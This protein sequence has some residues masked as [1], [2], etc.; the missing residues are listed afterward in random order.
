MVFSGLFFLC[1]FLPVTLL[2]YYVSPGLKAKNIVLTLFSLLF[3]AWGEPIYFLLM[4]LC[5]YV[6]YMAAR[7]ICRGA[8]GRK[9][10]L[11]VSLTISLGFLVVFKY[12]GLMAE[13]LNLIPFV[14][15][16]VPEIAL[17]IGISFY[18]F[19]ALSY[20]LDIYSGRDEP[21]KRFIDFLLY[22]S[23]FPQLIAGPILR[24]RDL[25]S[26]LTYREHSLHRFYRG[27]V[28]F[29]VGLCKKVIIANHAGEVAGEMLA[30]SST[31]G[32]WYGIILFALQI[33]FDF[34]GYSDM[35]VGLGRM[36]GFEYIEN[37][38]YPYISRSVTEFWRR[39]HIS[40][41]T[42][43]RDY[44]YIPMGGKYRHQMLNIFTVWA[45]TGIWHGAS[46]NFLFWGLYYG[47]LLVLEKKFLLKLLSRL[48]AAV[49]WL[50][51]TFTVLI[52]W[53]F[54]YFTDIGQCG[55]ALKTMFSAANTG[56]GDVIVSL[57]TNVFFLV[58]AVIASTPLPAKL[59]KKLL[60]ED[61]VLAVSFGTLFNTAAILL[62]AALLVNSSYN[63]F[64][65]FRF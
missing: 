46:W 27:T 23:L 63:P 57:K 52:G 21:Q 43:F 20:T 49:G 32:M 6:N 37:F 22:V 42:W 33:Y 65:Y 15:L 13:T 35:A 10:I 17:P 3:Y 1:V 2:F 58:I 60:P 45:L 16:P 39:W 28:R 54:F 14:N 64:L 12:A 25:S 38:N 26:Q 53:T 24:Y 61:S 47:I 56:V 48:P 36:F 7:L 55:T 29:S 44:V 41:G 11:W 5:T 31:L 40:L 51:S 9:A 18:T 34:S 19:Q 30:G 4:I 8:R 59:V 62:C 50:Y